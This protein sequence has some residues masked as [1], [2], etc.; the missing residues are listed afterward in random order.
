M[1]AKL[2]PQGKQQYF[3]AA[4]VPLIGGR[5]YTYESGTPS[6]PKATWA[7]AAKTA[8][9]SNPIILDGR[10]EATVFWDGAYKV[11][12]R[13][14]ADASIWTIDGIATDSDPT[15]LVLAAPTSGPT[16]TVN[17][18]GTSGL[19]AGIVNQSTG[20]NSLQAMRASGNSADERVWDFGIVGDK[21]QIRA[22]NDADA[23]FDVGFEIDRSGASAA[24]AKVR[25]PR[26]SATGLQNV[27]TYEEGTFTVSVE[28]FTTVI[29]PTARWVRAGSQLLLALDSFFG[30][31]NGTTMRD[32]TGAIPSRLRPQRTYKYLVPIVDN[33]VDAIGYVEIF[34]N[35]NVQFS[36]NLTGSNWTAAG[37]K[38]TTGN[39][40]FSYPLV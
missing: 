16:L 36:P 11:E 20:V 23:A 1:P 27:A 7:D 25:E 18:V 26:F 6:T 33:G 13:D 38:G 15:A 14:A 19:N 22:V 17:N 40:S 35:G 10:G 24:Q 30:T 32:L 28:G 31:S 29:T 3:T 37:T 9:N 12:L 4:G 8:P 21:F 39:L 2:L 5:L 34:A